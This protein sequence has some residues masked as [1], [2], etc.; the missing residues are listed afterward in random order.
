MGRITRRAMLAAAGGAAA[1]TMLGAGRRAAAA[2]AEIREIK[3][4]S[5]RPDLYH[6]WPTLVRCR[7]GR[8]LMTYSGGPRPISAPSAAS[9]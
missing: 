1:G 5:R 3:V 8:L 4:I 6:G 9:S 2:K 7:N